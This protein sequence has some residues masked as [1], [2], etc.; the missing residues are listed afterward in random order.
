MSAQ[1]AVYP[2]HIEGPNSHRSKFCA[3]TDVVHTWSKFRF[4]LGKNYDTLLEIHTTLSTADTSLLRVHKMGIHLHPIRAYY[5][6]LHHRHNS[7]SYEMT[8]VWNR[9]ECDS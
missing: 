8:L 5:L 6:S 4:I 9:L 1:V 7:K 2:E 3:H